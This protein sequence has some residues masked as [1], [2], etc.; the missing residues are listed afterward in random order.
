MTARRG[1]TTDKLTHPNASAF[2]RGM[3]GPSL[4]ALH[5]AAITSLAQLTTWTEADLGKLHGM[6]PKGLRILK[7]ALEEQGRSLRAE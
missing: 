3:S 1:S 5:G 6:G 4:R 2:P 7:A